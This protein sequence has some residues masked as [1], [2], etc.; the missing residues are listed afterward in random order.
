MCLGLFCHISRPLLLLTHTLYTPYAHLI[1]TMC[2]PQRPSL[3]NGLA[4]H[5]ARPLFPYQYASFAILVGLFCRLRIPSAHHVHT[6][7]S[8][9]ATRPRASH[10]PGCRVCAPLQALHLRRAAGRRQPAQ[11]IFEM[12]TITAALLLLLLVLYTCTHAHMHTCTHAHMHTR[13]HAHIRAQYI[14]MRSYTYNRGDWKYVQNV[15][16]LDCG[17]MQWMSSDESGSSFVEVCRIMTFPSLYIYLYI[18]ISHIYAYI[19]A[20]MHVCICVCACVNVTR[21]CVTP[22]LHRSSHVHTHTHTP[23]TTHHTHTC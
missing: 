19:Y 21:V 12:S 11:Q 20:H 18:Y 4:N 9:T 17:S 23:H 15:N 22:A 10:G 7:A 2:A 13:T 16:C 6:A 8:F 5:M 3:P 1:H 14:Y